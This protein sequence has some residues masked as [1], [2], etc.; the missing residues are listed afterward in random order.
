LAHV[1]FIHGIANKPEPEELLHDW[2][3]SLAD[4]DGIDLDALGVTSTM[5]YWADMLY[6]N[7]APE[8]SAQEESALE[9]EGT[10]DAD[11]ADLSWLADVSGA[12]RQF[13]ESL[14][15]KF[16]L[17]EVTATR[18]EL[19][20]DPIVPESTLEAIPLPPW[21]K[22][23]LMRVLLRDVHHYLYDVS[24]SPRPGE[25]FHIRTD[26]R[27]RM[28]EALQE[29]DG[30]P[31]PHL[32][33]GHSLGTVIAYDALTAIDGAPR[34]DALVTVGSPL[35]ISEVRDGL[36]PP[37][38]AVDGWPAKRLGN[39]TWWNVFDALDPVCGGLDR[40]I[41][42][43]YRSDGRSRVA[44]VG[45]SNTGYWRHSIGKYLGQPVVRSILSEIFG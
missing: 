26:I 10:V 14:G 17:A 19:A 25:T 13:V 15:Q 3:I 4:N 9:V 28:L 21:L 40:E 44:D 38:T 33:F 32:V 42:R 29:A 27:S 2:K 31:G 20:P 43:H 39:G 35:G 6:A 11:D 7:P 30:E 37:W 12:E 18:D 16:G 34:V 23:R 1:T 41:A 24:F 45:V 22:K 36:T 8:G 5:V